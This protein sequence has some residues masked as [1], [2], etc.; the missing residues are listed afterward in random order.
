MK[1]VHQC[2][3]LQL[4]EYRYGTLWNNT[5]CTFNANNIPISQICAFRCKQLTLELSSN[6]IL[7]ASKLDIPEIQIETTKRQQKY[8]PFTNTHIHTC[9]AQPIN[10][11]ASQ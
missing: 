5:E 4:V 7:I 2:R 9:V 8:D 11:C 10:L 6:A 1:Q 3:L